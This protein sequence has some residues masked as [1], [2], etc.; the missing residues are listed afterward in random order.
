MTK[1]QK[2]QPSK[3]K[4]D[5]MSVMSKGVTNYKSTN[6]ANK[7]LGK[8]KVSR[9][10]QEKVVRERD[11]ATKTQTGFYVVGG[12]IIH[13]R[14]DEDHSH[15]FDHENLN[16]I[17]VSHNRNKIYNIRSPPKSKQQIRK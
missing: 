12:G 11:L 4:K 15:E 9:V 10:S 2:L 14:N 17:H 13:E 5:D 16:M 3:K 6:M 7:S 8:N 1:N